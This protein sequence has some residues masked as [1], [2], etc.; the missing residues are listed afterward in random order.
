MLPLFWAELLTFLIAL[1]WLRFMDFVAHRGWVS[2]R[3]SRKVIHVGTGPF[4]VLCWLIFPDVPAARYLAALVPLLFTIQFAL[5]GLGVIKD[6]ATVEAICRTGD[7]REMLLGP[8]FYG[9]AFVV[10]TII[11]W[12]DS[13]IG[14]I[15]LMLICGGDGMADIIGSKVKSAPIPWAKQKSVAGSIAMFTGGWILSFLIL[16]AFISAGVFD[17]PISAIL[18]PL[19]ILVV[20]GTIIESLPF[21]DIDNLTIPAAT[22]LAGYF[23]F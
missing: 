22:M 13:P 14:I 4:F 15:A 17:Y 2:N 20:I 10:L 9:I 12:T 3:L 23:L 1:G 21:P 5:I 6:Q 8:L 7:R 11:Y 19:T 18:Q 16:A